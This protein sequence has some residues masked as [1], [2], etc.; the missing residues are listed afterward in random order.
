[1][2]Q[3]G[4]DAMKISSSFSVVQ[5][6]KPIQE[7]VTQS[8]SEGNYRALP[9][10]P[11]QSISSGYESNTSNDF[12]K[13]ERTIIAPQTLVNQQS[14]SNICSN[15]LPSGVEMPFPS[16]LMGTRKRVK[17][18]NKGE[19]MINSSFPLKKKALKKV[20]PNAAIQRASDLQLK[21]SLNQVKAQNNITEVIPSL[22]AIGSIH[23]A[24]TL[25]QLLVSQS[26]VPEGSSLAQELQHAY[27]QIGTV[28]HQS[29]FLV[30][31]DQ[32]ESKSVSL[33]VSRSLSVQ[34]NTSV[35]F[36]ISAT[37]NGNSLL[38]KL[39]SNLSCH[40]S[41]NVSSN[42]V[43]KNSVMLKL[44]SEFKTLPLDSTKQPVNKPLPTSSSS[45][46]LNTLVTQGNQQMYLVQLVSQNSKPVDSS[47]TDNTPLVRAF[48]SS[49][50]HQSYVSTQGQFFLMNSQSTS[51]SLQSQSI[52]TSVVNDAI[53]N[54]SV[55]NRTLQI[56]GL[57]QPSQMQFTSSQ[58]A[59]PHTLPV[60]YVTTVNGQNLSLAGAISYPVMQ[61][62]PKT[63]T[64][65]VSY[66]YPTFKSG[67][68]RSM[69]SSSNYVR[70]A[71]ATQS[72]T[73]PTNNSIE[74]EKVTEQETTNVTNEELFE[75]LQFTPASVPTAILSA[76]STFVS[77]IFRESNIEKKSPT[78]PSIKLN[79]L[80][81]T[82][83]PL[84]SGY[85]IQNIVQQ[86]NS[87]NTPVCHNGEAHASIKIS[88]QSNSLGSACNKLLLK[89]GKKI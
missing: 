36:P 22:R 73:V 79:P 68:V 66:L 8:F 14:S 81:E 5:P 64:S 60:H 24:Q 47:Q 12:L 30:R 3:T 89:Q 10:N 49:S 35:S 7:F 48:H 52:I 57:L 39:S 84:C 15:L 86:S 58:I 27:N 88:F 4:I 25:Q 63:Q 21:T 44:N 61:Y 78:N 54:T 50:P 67:N 83:I 72:I 82:S 29:S 16:S 85:T 75:K 1:M 77:N 33:S 28:E 62:L 40:E 46:P 43:D 41:T 59:M 11:K 38:T 19:L 87:V 51:Q 17:K 53:A 37:S 18:Q 31:Q 34:P 45:P 42:F 74:K 9:E 71:P 23:N 13:V 55:A 80:P 6:I 32:C 76:A 69:G 2:F 65:P 26:L 20:L 56:Q 70:I